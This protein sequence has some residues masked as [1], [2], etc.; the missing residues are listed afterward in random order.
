M[1]DFP[2]C[3]INLGLSITGRLADG[4]HSIE[5]MMYPLPLGDML[6][7][8]P[9]QSGE[10]HF[11]TSGVVID[12][13]ITDNL[14]HKAW[15]LLDDIYHIGAVNLHLH[16][17]VPSGAGLGGGS[18]D[19]SFTLKMLNA[20]FNLG[21][22]E[23]A[24]SGLAARLGMDCPFFISGKPALATGRGNILEHMDFSL[25]G[26]YIALVKPEIHIS[27]AMAYAGVIP[28]K[29]KVPIREI[30]KEPVGNWKSLLIN[31]FEFSVFKRYPQIGEIKE[32]L[33]EEG[34]LYAAMSGSGSA[35]FG[36]FRAPVAIRNSFPGCFI[37]EGVL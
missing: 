6:E 16:K 8:I 28:S 25:H 30:I 19:A 31:D 36:L 23:M 10:N 26:F 3:K 5:T 4:Y 20:I 17:I 2:N 13:D 15:K 18:A 24:L 12:G 11:A 34:A 21:L 32:I 9:S 29:K 35:V 7:I 22:D 33:Y 1:L 37:W 14:C 27:T